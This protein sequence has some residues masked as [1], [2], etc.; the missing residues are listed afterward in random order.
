MERLQIRRLRHD[1]KNY[2]SGL[3]GAVQVGEMKEAEMLI[4]GMLNDGIG[5]RTSEISRSGN[6]VV[7][8]LV[9]HKYALA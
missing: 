8:S 2:L 7:D 4:Q 9:N 1:M 6:I 3:L 5:N